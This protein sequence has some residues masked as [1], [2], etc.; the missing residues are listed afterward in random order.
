MQYHFLKNLSFILT[1]F[2]D[3]E[4]LDYHSFICYTSIEGLP[5]TSHSR[6][7]HLLAQTPHYSRIITARRG[8]RDGGA[9]EPLESL[10]AISTFLGWNKL[11]GHLPLQ[12]I[13][14]PRGREAALAPGVSS[15]LLPFTVMRTPLMGWQCT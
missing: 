11:P 12:A 8:L 1:I 10:R 7:P 13:C 6:L 14:P 15:A 3:L 2:A 4:Q 9:G 5:S